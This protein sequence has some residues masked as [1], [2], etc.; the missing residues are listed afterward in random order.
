MMRVFKSVYV[1]A[2]N[3]IRGRE[4]VL[5][6]HNYRKYYFDSVAEYEAYIEQMEQGERIRSQRNR[7]YE[8]GIGGKWVNKLVDF[9]ARKWSEV[10][11]IKGF[12]DFVG[13]I[14][15]N[16]TFLYHNPLKPP[17]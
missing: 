1:K 7:N 4:G 6:K 2:V 3:R 17:S 15:I 9:R 13:R 5:V 11:F 16:S 8:R 12:Q 10:T 14:L